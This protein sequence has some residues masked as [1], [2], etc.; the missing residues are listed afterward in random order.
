MTPAHPP[1]SAAQSPRSATPASRTAPSATPRN[2]STEPTPS[3]PAAA[4]T[5]TNSGSRS[6]ALSPPG[7]RPGSPAA[8]EAYSNLV[9]SRVAESPGALGLAGP[10][11]VIKAAA[12]RCHRAAFGDSASPARTPGNSS[13]T[14]SPTPRSS[15]T[16]WPASSAPQAVAPLDITADRKIVAD[17]LDLEEVL[18]QAAQLRDTLHTLLDLGIV[19]HADGEMTHRDLISAHFDRMRRGEYKLTMTR[20]PRRSSKAAR[21]ST[22]PRPHQP[23]SAAP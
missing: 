12:G 18:R 21:S 13:A 8:L 2:C 3:R 20:K 5:R 4:D 22:R 16:S 1:N 15:P 19:D 23:P 6:W 11:D 9:A 14:A 7:P 17:R 10:R